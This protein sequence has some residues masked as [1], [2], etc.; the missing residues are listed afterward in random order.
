MTTWRSSH[1]GEILVYT[2]AFH[3]QCDTAVAS[4]GNR[5]SDLVLSSQTCVSEVTVKDTESIW[6]KARACSY[7][8]SVVPNYGSIRSI[9]LY[10]PPGFL[11][12]SRE[13]CE[14]YEVAQAK[15][16]RS[17]AGFRPTS[18]VESEPFSFSAGRLDFKERRSIDI[19]VTVA[20]A[21]NSRKEL[22]RSATLARV[23]TALRDENSPRR[24]EKL[25]RGRANQRGNSRRKRCQIQPTLSDPHTKGLSHQIYYALQR[26]LEAYL[27]EWTRG[28]SVAYTMQAS[29]AKLRSIQLNVCFNLVREWRPDFEGCDHPGPVLVPEAILKKPR[30]VR[31]NLETSVIRRL[32][33][34]SPR[35]KN[36]S[37]L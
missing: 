28:P 20:A 25:H 33:I 9:R 36:K 32:S 24:H 7:Y 22:T 16:P 1:C 8:L 12:K 29:Y 2:G 10:R 21:G 30:V 37:Q 18:F 35:D 14:T 27:S 23:A 5:T 13:S 15:P 17:P 19:P 3:S 34:V 26:W 6:K 4:A 31:I 11:T